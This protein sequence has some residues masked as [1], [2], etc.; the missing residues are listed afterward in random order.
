[1]LIV[2]NKPNAGYN[3]KCKDEATRL[4]KAGTRVGMCHIS[5]ESTG[6]HCHVCNKDQPLP[7]EALPKPG[8]KVDLIAPCPGCKTPFVFAEI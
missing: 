6:F 5:N 4:V 7:V 1:M 3:G 8:T 2:S